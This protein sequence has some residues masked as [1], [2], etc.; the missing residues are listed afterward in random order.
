MLEDSHG[1]WCRLRLKLQLSGLA[2][3]NVVGPL[4]HSVQPHLMELS[5][6]LHAHGILAPP[7]PRNPTTYAHLIQILSLLGLLTI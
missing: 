6:I 2:V 7:I 3:V 5:A 4:N 1:G